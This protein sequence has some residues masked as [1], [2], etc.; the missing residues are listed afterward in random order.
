MLAKF[1]TKESKGRLYNETFH[2]GSISPFEL[3]RSRIIESNAFRRLD[4]KTQVFLGNEGEH[5]RNRL[6]HSIEAAQIARIV[7]RALNISVDLSENI[8]LAHDMGHAAFGHAGEE[9]LKEVMAEYGK[10]FDHN[11]HTLKIIT[12]LEQKHPL[13]N[14][15]NLC[16]ETI[17]GVVKHNGPVLSPSHIVKLYSQQHNLDLGRYSSLESQVASISDDIAYNNHDIDDGFRA[18]LINIDELSSIEVLGRLIYD[19][20]NQYPSIQDQKLI[21]EVLQRMRSLMIVDL[22]DT[23]R[24]NIDNFSI[25][26]VEDV[27]SIGRALACFS[28]DMEKNHLQIKDFL[29]RKLYRSPIVNRMSNKAKRIVKELFYLY[30]NDLGCLPK[31][32]QYNI[33]LLDKS[34]AAIV[35][36]DFIACMSDRY[37]MAEY[38]SFFELSS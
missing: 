28:T 6:T 25:K 18:G 29:M 21:Y 9:A 37:A 33:S 35:V 32:W 3:D 30:M 12:Q 8:A 36:C 24:Q 26:S 1:A 38:R 16:W 2:I 31:T 23:T 17:E 4:C 10:D 20:K 11:S 15:L 34:E 7:S 27:R 5:Y 22:I 19:V 14:G 13:F